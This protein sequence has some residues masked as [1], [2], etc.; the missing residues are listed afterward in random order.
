MPRDISEVC[1][2][3][4]RYA[5]LC[6]CLFHGAEG[7]HPF[8]KAIWTLAVGLQ[9]LGP[10]ITE[11]F[12]SLA[13]QPGIA[14]IYHG[15]ILRAIQ[16]SIY[17]Y[18]QHVASNIVEGMVFVE[19]P[20]FSALMQDLKRGTTFHLS[21]NWV[22]VPEQ[23]LDVA[24]AQATTMG[25]STTFT[26]AATVLTQASSATSISSVTHETGEPR[27]SVACIENPSRDT[28]FTSITMRPGGTTQVLRTNPPPANDAPGHEFCIA[29]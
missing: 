10:F 6:Q 22:E 3:L 9:N 19:M 27:S 8:V 24:T 7:A 1:I 11:R 20:S 26:G 28:D 17:D 15:R 16:L 23:Y 21:T 5:V 2:T 12:H 4:T 14:R 13:C 18:M 29:W 25:T